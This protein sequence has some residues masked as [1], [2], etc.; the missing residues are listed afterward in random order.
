[1]LFRSMSLDKDNLFFAFND[2]HNAVMFDDAVFTTVN[3]L[4]HHS[5]AIILNSDDNETVNMR[6]GE[7]LLTKLHRIICTNANLALGSETK[8]T[9]G[10][11]DQ[12]VKRL[13]QKGSPLTT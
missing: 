4:I 10:E 6:R 5:P 2:T 7:N 8:V 12:F 3:T 9:T 1:M 13:A 11:N